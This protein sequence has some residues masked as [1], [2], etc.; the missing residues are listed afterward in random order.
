MLFGAFAA[1]EMTADKCGNREQAKACNK[2]VVY[3]LATFAAFEFV[4]YFLEHF[5]FSFFRCLNKCHILEYFKIS[6]THT[7]SE[8]AQ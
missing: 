4:L 5:N 8:M 2:D 3:A 1:C 6:Y 7:T